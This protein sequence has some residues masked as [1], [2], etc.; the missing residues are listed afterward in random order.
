M[1]TEA[2][3]KYIIDLAVIKTKE[4]KEVKELLH[5]SGI[6][7]P[8]A[9]IVNSAGT[10]AEICNALTDLQASR[11]IDVLTN[12]KPPARSNSYAAGRTRKTIAAL[13]DIKATID[14]WGF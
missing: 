7:E 8:G 12:M 13:D 9:A 10:L 14:D 2:Q 11:L 5:A 3:N 6:V 4:F 1:A